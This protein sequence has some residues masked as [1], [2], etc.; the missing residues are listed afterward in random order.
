[1]RVYVV[2]L[3]AAAGLALTG[4]CHCWGAK[5]QEGGEPRAIAQTITDSSDVNASLGK[6]ITFVGEAANAKLSAMVHTDAMMLYCIEMADWPDE[7]HGKQVQVTG[8]LE[9]T[10]QF[11]ATVAKDGAI[12]QG[13]A[14]GDVLLRSVEWELVE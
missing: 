7:V 1:M 9:R 12:S 2:V 14:G 8:V 13:T 4:C 10:D 3:L 5:G 11:K 6:R